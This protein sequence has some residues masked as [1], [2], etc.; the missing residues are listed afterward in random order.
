MI[1]ILTLL[2]DKYK[3]YYNSQQKAVN[4]LEKILIGIN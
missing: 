1:K 4:L 2:V 3:D